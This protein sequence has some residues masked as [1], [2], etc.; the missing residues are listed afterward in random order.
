MYTLVQFTPHY[1]KHEFSDADDAIGFA[2]ATGTGM[3]I[4]YSKFYG[5]YNSLSREIWACDY[6]EIKKLIIEESI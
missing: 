4:L 1:E 2:D 6:D 5:L 3:A